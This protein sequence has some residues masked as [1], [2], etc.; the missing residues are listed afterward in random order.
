M[1]CSSCGTMHR[2]HNRYCHRTIRGTARDIAVSVS[3][4]SAKSSLSG[5]NTALRLMITPLS[6]ITLWRHC[7]E[8]DTDAVSTSYIFGA[9]EIRP[10]VTEK[11][12]LGAASMV[13]GWRSDNGIIWKLTMAAEE[14]EKLYHGLLRA[15]ERTF[16]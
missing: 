15:V 2:K 16:D 14:C 8:P 13:S 11:T 3:P 4:I 12:V 5:T 7:S 10:Q 6:G 1:T 9:P